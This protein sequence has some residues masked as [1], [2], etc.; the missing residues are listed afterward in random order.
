MGDALLYSVIDSANAITLLPGWDLQEAPLVQRVASRTIGGAEQTYDWAKNLGYFMSLSTV[1][2]AD[3]VTMN[4]WWRDANELKFT[5]DSSQSN[6]AIS[7]RIMNAA[8]PFQS[9]NSF[10]GFWQTQLSLL[11]TMPSSFVS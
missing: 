1:T 3:A 8:M 4:G 9:Y 11:E 2:S 7:C 5:E 10:T 6:H